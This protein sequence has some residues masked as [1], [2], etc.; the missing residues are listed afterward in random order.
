MLIGSARIEDAEI[1]AQAEY[2][3][4]AAQEGLLAAM[5]GE[6][7]VSAF[8]NK[9]Q[10]LST[11]GLYIVVELDGLP[12]GHLFL[13]PLSL[14][15]TRH[16]SQLTIVV[17]PG[18]TRKGYGRALMDYA[19]QWA[20]ESDLVEK[21]ELRVR[22]TNPGAI[23]LYESLGFIREGELWNRIK[24]ETGYAHD[25]CMALFVDGPAAKQS[26]QLKPLI[27]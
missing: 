17:H 14:S 20:R 9:I 22:S 27:R 15:S 12:V 24:L 13:E 19:I 11:G 23:A 1:L 7:P 3:T 5:P 26:D 6:I 4:A 21:I 2:D 18:H 25:I 10:K 8:R 16:V